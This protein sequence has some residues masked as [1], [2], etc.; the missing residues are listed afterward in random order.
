MDLRATIAQAQMTGDTVNREG[1]QVRL[2]EELLNVTIRV[3]P[4]SLPAPLPHHYVIL[5][6]RGHLVSRR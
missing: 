4:L 5:F 2:N 6:R 1:V 3:V